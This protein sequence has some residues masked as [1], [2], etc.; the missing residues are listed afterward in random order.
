MTNEENSQIISLS[1]ERKALDE[2]SKKIDVAIVSLKD[3][4]DSI[5]KHKTSDEITKKLN[6]LE[7]ILT[8]ALEWIKKHDDKCATEQKKIEDDRIDTK[9]RFKQFGIAIVLY[10]IYKGLDS[11][12]AFWKELK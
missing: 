4:H 3:L 9:K 6:D 11:I 1:E 7:R 8:G 2:V 10:L 12:Y 5:N